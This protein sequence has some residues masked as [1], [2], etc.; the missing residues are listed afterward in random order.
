ME[1]QIRKWDDLYRTQKRAW[2]GV[3]NI[4]SVPFDEGSSVLE[5]GCGNGKTLAALRDAG[6]R[7]TGVDFSQEA[8]NASR[9]LLGEDTDLRCASVLDLPFE[10]EYFDGVVIF[11]VLEHITSEQERQASSEIFR[12]MKPGSRLMLKSFSPGDMRSEK[13]ERIDSSSVIRGNGILYKYRTE[14]E[15]IEVFRDFKPESIRTVV[16][17]TRFGTQR[18]RIEAVFLKQ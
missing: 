7:V 8:V 9:S 15:I 2:R 12:V 18:S 11:H 13:G 10:D 14:D 6:Y 4:G 5:L 1:D 16:E 17:D 3:T